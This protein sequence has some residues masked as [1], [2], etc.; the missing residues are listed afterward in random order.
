MSH[1]C[2]GSCFPQKTK[3]RRLV[4]DISF[5][6]QLECHR[7]PQIDIESFISDA[8]CTATQFDGFPVFARHQL[9]VIK[10]LRWLIWCCR[11]DLLLERRLAGLN[12]ASKTL[13]KHAYRT[14][15][16]RSRKLVAAGR[17]GALGLRTHCPNRPSA[18]V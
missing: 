9:V 1:F 13:P 15:F 17:T 3:H 5:T 11:L 2:C 7:K 14:E 4:A 6:D 10:S 16:H 18:A 8:H 12:R